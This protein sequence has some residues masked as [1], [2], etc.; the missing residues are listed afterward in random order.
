MCIMVNLEY[1]LWILDLR[2]M[3]RERRAYP[4]TTY[5]KMREKEMYRERENKRKK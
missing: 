5:R 4:Q 3:M 2:P 1:T